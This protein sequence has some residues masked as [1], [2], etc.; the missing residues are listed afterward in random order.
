MNRNSTVNDQSPSSDELQAI[1]ESFRQALL[2]GRISQDG[3][4]TFDFEEWL[5]KIDPAHRT[6]VARH[7]TRVRDSH[8]ACTT[9]TTDLHSTSFE[10][11]FEH[12]D[13]T[14][15][16]MEIPDPSLPERDAAHRAVFSC[17]TLSRLPENVKLALA[18]GI[19]RREFP[20]G[21]LLLKQGQPA[22]G[23]HLVLSGQVEISDSSGPERKRIDVDGAGSIL[24]EMSLLTGQNCSADVVTLTPAV[25]LVLPVEAFEKLRNE[26]PE[27]EIALSQLV[28]D[29]LGQRPHDALCGKCLN[30]YTLVRCINRGAMG[31]VYEALQEADRQPRALKMLRHRYIADSRALSRFDFEV[32]L[33]SKLQH[34]NVVRTYGHFVAYRTRFLIL[35]LCDGADLKKTLLQHGPVPEPTVRAILGQIAAGLQ[36]AHAHGALHLDLKP[37]NVLVDRSGRIAITD[38]GLGRLIESDGVE[39]SIAGTP[40]YMSPEQF[41]GI[42]IGPASDWYALGCLAYEL[43]T[44][45]LL[46]PEID[47]TQMFSR[48]H[49]LADELWSAGNVSEELRGILYAALEPMVEY[50]H[51]DLNVLSAW[52]RP[53]PELAAAIVR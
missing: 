42:D 48:K 46:F 43:L 19:E 22:T 51:L 23:L 38:F 50:R 18:S 41:K 49:F 25:V 17:I 45:H 20:E 12:I 27:I 52:A 14:P 33:L 44:G 29:R 47:L 11:A 5:L 39:E 2:A 31:V 21:A 7:L 3:N 26:F 6:R 16:S 10:V 40:S 1:Y 32:D 24:G 28:S 9:E 13:P 53:V 34:E 4:S 15:A 30:G 8:F 35:E 36:Y 37:A